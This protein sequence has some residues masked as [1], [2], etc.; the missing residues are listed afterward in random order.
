MIG[1]ELEVDGPPGVPGLSVVC[2]PLDVHTDE[3]PADHSNDRAGD[4]DEELLHIHAPP[5]ETALS[6][7]ATA[8]AT[9]AHLARTRQNMLAFLFPVFVVLDVRHRPQ[10]RSSRRRSAA[11]LA[12]C[13]ITSACMAGSV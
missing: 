1:T 9:R 5:S 8:L 10:A 3:E 12:Y 13:T 6:D 4:A 11:G 7:V 2:A